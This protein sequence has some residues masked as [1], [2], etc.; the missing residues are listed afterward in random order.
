VDNDSGA[1]EETING[2]GKSESLHTPTQKRRTNGTQ[3]AGGRIV[4]LL[5]EER[6]GASTPEPVVNGISRF[7][8]VPRTDDVS[9]DGSSDF[10]ARA[11]SPVESIPDDSPSVQ[12]FRHPKLLKYF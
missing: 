10:P 7:Q 12:V 1:E 11:G 5:E 6:G 4:E 2:D 3:A 8:R 9:E